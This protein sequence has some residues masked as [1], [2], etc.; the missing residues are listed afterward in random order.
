MNNSSSYANFD[1]KPP[2]YKRE[3]ESFYDE[4]QGVPQLN[5]NNM[6]IQDVYRT[7]FLFT[8]DH[9]KDYKS[10][11]W[12]AIRNIHSNTDLSKMFFSDKNVKRVQKQIK[13]AVYKKTNGKYR[14]DVDQDEKDILIAMRA[15][16]L[17]YGRFLPGKIVRQVKRLNKQV[18]DEVLPSMITELKQYYGYLNEIN[19]PL[20][21]IA[22]PLNMGNAGR[23]SLPSISTVWGI[24]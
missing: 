20:K 16:Y 23:K 17:E 18:L 14:L 11:T 19:G 8:Q 10:K 21:P 12:T 7:P 3:N 5:E 6:T 15:V 22:R 9:Q 13:T 2:F 1:T 24:K 4:G